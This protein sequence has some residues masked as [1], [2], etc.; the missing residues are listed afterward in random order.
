MATNRTAAHIPP[1]AGAADPKPLLEERL[2]DHVLAALRATAVTLVL[3]GLLYPLAMTAIAGTFFRGAAEGSLV[4]DATGRVVGSDLL[5]QPFS[6]A[7]YFQPRPSA[8]G[9]KG[10]DTLQSGG[11]NLG[12]TSKKLK[13]GAAATLEKLRKENPEAT[14]PVPVEL[15]TA[16]GSGLDPHLSPEAALWQAARVARARGVAVDRVRAVVAENIEGRDLGVFG[17]PRVNVLRMNL[18]LDRRF[19]APAG[20]SAASAREPT[21]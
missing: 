12:P 14:G 16:S 21:R 9:E 19:G 8:A 10:F 6:A 7:A 1:P 13:D 11:S 17:E 15:L 2:A 4:T 3:T 20:P 5:A 18:A